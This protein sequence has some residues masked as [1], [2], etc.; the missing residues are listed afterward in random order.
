MPNQ[1]NRLVNELEL[2]LFCDLAAEPV[3]DFYVVGGVFAGKHQAHHRIQARYAGRVFQVLGADVRDELGQLF[4]VGRPAGRI[5]AL[6]AAPSESVPR[7]E[8][9]EGVSS[10]VNATAISGTLLLWPLTCGRLL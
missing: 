9:S 7:G 2:V 3:Q 4:S 10:I 5:S 1:L 8:L 6:A